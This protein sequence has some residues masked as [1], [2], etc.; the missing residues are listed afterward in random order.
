VLAVA[1]ASSLPHWFEPVLWSDPDAINYQ[2]KVLAFRGQDERTALHRLF[3]SPIAAKFR[4][5]EATK[6]PS[7]RRSSNPYL[8]D[9]GTRFFRRRLV[10]PLM[11]AGIYPVFGD[12]SLL[13]V[14][15]VGYLLLALA[16]YALL[17]RRFSST[18]S[19]VATIACIL[20][21][22]L[23]LYSF[24]PMTDSWGVLLETCAL[25]AAVLTFDRGTRWLT[26]WVA[27]IAALSVTR[28]DTIV[29]LV[30]VACLLIQQRERRSALLTV[31]GVAAALPAPLIFGNVSVRGNLAFVFSNYYPPKDDSWGFVVSNYFPH[32]RHLI[33]EDL[34]YGTH[35]GWAAPLWYVG[36]AV[37][38]VGVA[39]LI[40][41]VRAADPFFPL[42]GYSL[43]GAVLFVALFADYSGLREELVF[44]PPIAVGLALL[45]DKASNSEALKRLRARLVRRAALARGR[46]GAATGPP[47]R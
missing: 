21:P 18:T 37:L 11:A 20:L 27:A 38:A 41:S 34:A 14:S 1:A 43:V 44:I 24:V 23:R 28:D 17:R 25:L 30:A 9:Y 10:V 15:M 16:L 19:A 31:T 45:V 29:P 40:K 12:R 32:V 3:A 39:L 8:I 7:R 33:R 22:P 5:D 47:S 42:L 4:R 26:F 13:T 46:L 2:A 36:L 35:V 6:P